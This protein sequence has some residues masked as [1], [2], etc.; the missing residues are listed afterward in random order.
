MGAECLV[1]DTDRLREDWL[2]SSAGG[3]EVASL[4]LETSMTNAPV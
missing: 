2:A 1:P 4:H 3:W